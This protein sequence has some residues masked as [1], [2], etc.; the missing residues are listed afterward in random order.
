VDKHKVDLSGL[1]CNTVGVSYKAFRNQP[2]MCT[3]R[4]ES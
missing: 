4:P 3:N 1:F 2:E